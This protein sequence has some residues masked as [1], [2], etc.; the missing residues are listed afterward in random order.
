[1]FECTEAALGEEVLGPATIRLGPD[2]IEVNGARRPA[3]D[4]SLLRA[5]VKAYVYPREAMGFGDVKLMGAIGAFFGWTSI[6][7][8][9]LVSS[10]AGS[11]VGVVLLLTRRVDLQGRIPYGPYL[12]LA[13]LVWLL[14]GGEWWMR[15]WAWM[16]GIW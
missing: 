13:A 7:F 6:P 2:T 4:L 9:L 3:G 8:T 15:Y 16:Q 10:L 14:G 12:A 11:I 5:T 1:M